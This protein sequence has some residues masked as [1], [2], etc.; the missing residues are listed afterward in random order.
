MAKGLGKG[1]NAFFP[2]IEKQEDASI[3]EIAITECRPNPYQPRKT[4]HADAIEELKESI[5]EYG[6][7]QPLIARKS[8]K[9][10][11]IVVGERRF[12]AAKEA[13]L[14]TIPV[15]VK[16][17]S[18]EKMMEIALLENLQR[19]DLTPIEEAHAYA[20]LMS[21]LKVTQ[22]ELSKRLG[23]SRSHI[24]NIVRLLSLPN[25]VVAY[26][27]NGELSMGHG[28]ALLGLKDKDKI[29]PFVNKIRQEKLNVRQVEK[30]IIELNERPSRK[31]EKPKKDV[32]IEERETALRERL[33]T[34]VNIH[35]GKRKGKIEIEF[36]ND[37]DLNRIIE[38]LDK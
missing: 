24:A 35:K 14:K 5:L 13:G 28:R 18:D 23:K 19:E 34:A 17:L 37:E 20:N 7:I 12:R 3:Q 38:F 22:E 15:I 26:I 6:I 27:N 2:E 10:Y 1:L 21:E 31:T 33:G 30:L 36:Y 32:F 29:M 8:I 11:E 9:G 16:D 4:F 25:Q